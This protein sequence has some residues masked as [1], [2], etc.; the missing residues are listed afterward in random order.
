VAADGIARSIA[1]NY[2]RKFRSEDFDD[3]YQ[4]ARVGLIKAVRAYDCTRGVAFSTFAWKA[5]VREVFWGLSQRTGIA[6][7]TRQTD[8]APGETKEPVGSG[9][10]DS[11]PRTVSLD[12]PDIT[13]PDESDRTCPYETLT[14][15]AESQVLR[16]LIRSLPDRER[17]I[18]ER[19]YMTDDD[20]RESFAR[21]ASTLGITPQRAQQIE[22]QAMNRLRGWMPADEERVLLPMTPRQATLR[23]ETARK[24]SR[25]TDPRPAQPA[26]PARPRSFRMDRRTAS[27]YPSASSWGIPRSS[28]GALN[29]KFQW[30]PMPKPAVTW[31]GGK[32]RLLDRLFDALPSDIA[33]YDQ[34]V[35]P[36]LGG[37]SV[38]I[39]MLTIGTFQE[40]VANDANGRLIQAYR[41][42]REGCGEFLG[43]LAD[44]EAEYALM[45]PGERET[46]YYRR[47][48][49]Y[50][51][52]GLSPTEISTLLVFLNRTCFNGKY[53]E[54]RSGQ[55]NV[56]WGKKTSF[57]YD[58]ENLTR[59][60]ELLRDDRLTLTA[61]D[62]R[63]LEARIGDRAFVYADSP[64][65]PTGP[66]GYATYRRGDFDNGTQ[67]ELRD[68]LARLDRR[69]V[70][71]L[72]SN[73]DTG[74]T[75]ELYRDY[76]IRQIT[77]PRCVGRGS[78]AATAVPE[79]LVSNY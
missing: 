59:L 32:T 78:G 37:G 14:R 40:Y 35:E 47:R 38:L 58:P 60:G 36:F 18:I 20:E 45:A 44:W 52:P 4:D 69:G 3:L 39:R 6:R 27:G 2:L 50:N 49:R 13:V 16:T 8:D 41:T 65:V 5:A 1:W 17:Y 76:N 51:E 21:L 46:T 9:T 48:A 42:I 12:D 66:Q 70:A 19:R 23:T 25:P 31:P 79:L 54:N 71:W 34:Y 24:T 56:S 64:Y 15:K 61:G 67:A 57:R 7:P 33:A 75:R 11:R 28:A 68:F 53:A 22:R 29:T 26:G 63:N 55:F 10:T 72:A 43:L 30:G 62:F 73:S 77:A 74:L